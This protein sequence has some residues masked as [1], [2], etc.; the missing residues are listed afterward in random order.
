MNYARSTAC[1]FFFYYSDENGQ[2]V[3]GSVAGW[4]QLRRI[5]R[6]GFRCWF[7]YRS[8]ITRN[9]EARY[10]RLI[11]LN[12]DRQL[13]LPYLPDEQVNILLAI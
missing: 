10:Y 5:M 7:E 9:D 11:L 12:E 13:A 4:V 2:N 1:H 8:A 3:V 6:R